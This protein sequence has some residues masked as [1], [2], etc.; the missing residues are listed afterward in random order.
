M[1]RL[2]SIAGAVVV[3]GMG[4]APFEGAVFTYERVVL[5]S[6]A[7]P[8]RLEP[9]ATLLAGA[10]A[11]RYEEDG[12]GKAP[13]RWRGGLDDFRLFD[14]EGREIEYLLLAPPQ[15]RD[16]WRKGTVRPFAPT[17]RASGFDVDLGRALTTDRI[18]IEGMPAPFMKR[19]RTEASLDGQRW[20]VV[21]EQATVFDLPE[22]QLRKL[23]ID[24]AP[25]EY[26]WVR[27]TWD[28]RSSAVA[29]L[30]KSVAAR[31]ASQRP[32]P[33]RGVAVEFAARP[34][35]PRRSRYHL[36]LP[37]PNLPVVAIELDV[38]DPNVFRNAVISETRF[39]GGVAIS[40]PIGNAKLRK[41]EREGVV[42]ADLEIP[43]RR[44]ATP[45]LELAIED[46][47]GR[48]L[49]VSAVRALL[50]PLPAIY[51]ESP[52]GAPLT[53]RYGNASLGPPGYDLEAKRESI[54][55]QR[56]SAARWGEVQRIAASEAAAPGPPLWGPRLEPG[57]FLYRRAIPSGSFGLTSLLLDL[58]VLAHSNDLRDV[59]IIARDGR[60]VPYVR[61][62]RE[63]PLIVALPLSPRESGGGARISRY[64]MRLPF[65]TI[66]G[67][68]KIVF[69]TPA[70][71]FERT[72]TLELPA[73]ERLGRPRS[74][75]GVFP[76]RSTS[77]ELEP[78]PLVV[79][80][81]LEGADQLIVTIDEGDNDPLTLATPQLL[82][83]S[84]RVRFYYPAEAQL[85]LAY[86]N[87]RLESPRYDLALAAPRL[88]GVAAQEVTAAPERRPTGS[89]R[90]ERPFW[91]ALILAVAAL[92]VILGRIIRG[93]TQPPKS[94]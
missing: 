27:V 36:T 49:A 75:I 74:A 55:P 54:E 26:R 58:P 88:F 16:E 78:P 92:L 10:R 5:P 44:P 60:Q 42:A 11:L 33:R 57:D 83:P 71:L 90:V 17:R 45:S 14:I 6:A 37:A 4:A 56:A 28:D 91:I 9:D 34:S 89:G 25:G 46:A 29:P 59:R 18:R 22:E 73:N 30:P 1:R 13:A 40:V 76:W 62:K 63:E 61:E 21:N 41:T 64:R 15:E 72:L 31:M 3:A 68:V 8:N 65:D 23:S 93:A 39:E 52:D 2:L 50:A 85:F 32:V 80:L 19:A 35:E 84:H 70:R 81:S 94:G 87:P 48:A 47:D 53:A 86:G 66:P 24:V 69:R 79:E 82:I 7:G 38:A 12:S 51:L 77:P 43:I 67:R 20:F